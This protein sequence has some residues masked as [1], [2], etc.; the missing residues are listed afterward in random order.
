MLCCT[1]LPHAP[2][3]ELEAASAESSSSLGVQTHF[4]VATKPISSSQVLLVHL[5]LPF[6]HPLVCTRA[7][8]SIA[9]L[10]FEVKAPEAA[11]LPQSSDS[12]ALMKGTPRFRVFRTLLRDGAVHL[13]KQL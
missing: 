13:L 6:P 11:R 3:A 10:I 5:C 1:A 7:T 4:R 9:L 2:Y 12:T 8:M